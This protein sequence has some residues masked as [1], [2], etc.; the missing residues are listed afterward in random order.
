MKVRFEDK[1]CLSS[2]VRSIF[3][4]RIIIIFSKKSSLFGIQL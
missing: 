4:L 2:K 1:K 3:A